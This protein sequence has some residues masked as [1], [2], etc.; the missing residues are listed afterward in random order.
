MRINAKT[1]TQLEQC[2][3]HVGYKIR[4]EKGN[5][6]SGYCIITG[7]KTIII[8]Q[9]INLEGR[10]YCLIEILKQN[11]DILMA[12][13]EENQKFLSKF[14]KEEKEKEENEEKTKNQA[15]VDKNMEENKENEDKN[16]LFEN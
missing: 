14:L 7:Q 13:E 5:F 1:L 15:I 2:F 16:N 6:Q 3:A 11:L 8:N 9:F 10:V 4:Y 12:Q